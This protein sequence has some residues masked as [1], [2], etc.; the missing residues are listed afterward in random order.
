MFPRLI[1]FDGLCER[2]HSALLEINPALT[3]SLLNEQALE[4]VFGSS[5]FRT[6]DAALTR[7]LTNAVQGPTTVAALL[8]ACGLAHEDATAILTDLLDA[9]VLIDTCPLT[10]SAKKFW[11]ARKISPAFAYERLSSRRFVA[12]DSMLKGVGDVLRGLGLDAKQAH[13]SSRL[14]VC[15][16]DDLEAS[17][18]SLN[19][20][21]VVVP[22]AFKG[23][24]VLWGPVF[25]VAAPCLSCYRRLMNAR[26]RRST[27]STVSPE[28]TLILQGLA[29]LLD[30]IDVGRAT[31][32][33]IALALV[34]PIQSGCVDNI[35]S[36]TAC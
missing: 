15:T 18:S 21:D 17:I 27:S 8:D 1:Q 4:V 24:T 25:D 19:T 2:D 16:S 14:V 6:S 23:G 36:L 26:R 31:A 5:R 9:G 29:S 34:C 30:E 35:Q 11:L 3:F 20:S 13:N 12:T 32:H 7:L 22:F 33:D 10:L 28:S